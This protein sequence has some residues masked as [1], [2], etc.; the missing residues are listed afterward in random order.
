MNSMKQNRLAYDSTG[1]ATLYPLPPQYWEYDRANKRLDTQRQETVALMEA[2]RAKAKA[3]KQ[4]LPL[5]KFTGVQLVIGVEGTPAV[6]PKGAPA[7]A[8]APVA[9]LAE[10]VSPGNVNPPPDPQK[11]PEPVKQPEAPKAPGG[12]RPLKY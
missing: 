9:N 7:A 1:K 6:A 10:E 11:Q 8:A 4:Q 3:V 12:E 5:P 2:L